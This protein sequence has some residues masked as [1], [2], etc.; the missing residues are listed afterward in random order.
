M[1]TCE[2]GLRY[3]LRFLRDHAIGQ[4]VHLAFKLEALILCLEL[5]HLELELGVFRS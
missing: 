5:C 1:L 2:R 4:G 3:I